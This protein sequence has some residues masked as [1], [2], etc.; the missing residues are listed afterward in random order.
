MI[1]LNKLHDIT[2]EHDVDDIQFTITDS[3]VTLN[4]VLE[5]VESFLLACGY[6]FN[7]SLGIVGGDDDSRWG[8][9]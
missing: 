9:I 7:G 6:C 3:D 2:N 1:I 5:V 8:G 4:K